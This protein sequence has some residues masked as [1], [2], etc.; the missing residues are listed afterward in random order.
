M[1]ECERE[2]KC[3]FTITLASNKVTGSHV[4][5][6]YNMCT[7]RNHDFSNSANQQNDNIKVNFEQIF[8]QF[9]L[10]IRYEAVTV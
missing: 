7:I 6:I 8:S 3:N 5:S 10:Q 4:F 2:R 1:K 9:F